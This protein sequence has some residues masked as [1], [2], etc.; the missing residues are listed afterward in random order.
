ML[1]HLLADRAKIG[2][3][4]KPLKLGVKMGTDEIKKD[5][6]AIDVASRSRFCGRDRGRPLGHMAALVATPSPQ[7]PG[8]TSS[9]TASNS[10]M[11]PK[12]L[13]KDYWAKRIKEYES[14]QIEGRNESFPVHFWV[15]AEETLARMVYENETSRLFS[16]VTLGENISIR[17]FTLSRQV[18]PSAKSDDKLSE[19]LSLFH[20]VLSRRKRCRCSDSSQPATARADL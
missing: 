20:P 18:N 9:T 11:A 19:L 5:D 12:Q 8:T 16:S 14:A 10:H 17:N 6:V 4:P 2:K 13:P 3:T 1:Y 7:L 15:G